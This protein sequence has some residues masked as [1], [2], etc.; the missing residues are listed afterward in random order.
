MPRGTRT[1]IA[2]GIYQDNLG[3]AAVVVVGSGE[4]RQSKEERFPALTPLKTMEAW[5]RRTRQTLAAGSLA[6]PSA[7]GPQALAADAEAYLASVTSM[8]SY[9]ARRADLEAWL[10]VYGHRHRHSLTHQELTAQLNTWVEQGVADSTINH[11]RQALRALYLFCDPDETPPI[12]GTQCR[13]SKPLEARALPW[14][15]VLELVAALSDHKSG[16]LLRV[17]AHTG[18]PPARIARLQPAHLDA[19]AKTIFLIGRRKG[20]GTKSQTLRLTDD[21]VAALQQ[22]FKHFP[23]GGAVQKES[24]AVEFMKAVGRVNAQRATDKRPPI[25]PPPATR[26]YDLRHS[27]GTEA[28]RRSG[29]LKAVAA[30]LDVS[31][32][33]AERYTLGAVSTQVD[34]VIAAMNAPT[35]DA[36]K[37]GRLARANTGWH[38]ANRPRSASHGAAK[39]GAKLQKAKATGEPEVGTVI[40]RIGP[41]TA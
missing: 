6:V 41:E 25:P 27:F 40:G 7:S 9:K 37:A 31:L 16:A 36:G 20:Q 8:P 29:D 12:D 26:P 11:R 15:D 39:N 10:P 17:L 28:Y 14:P 34:K 13:P 18:F 33:T 22:Y 38:G 19:R 2:P 32:E 21:G 24:W 30:A 5:Q 35:S 3:F 1:R 23:Q 4:R